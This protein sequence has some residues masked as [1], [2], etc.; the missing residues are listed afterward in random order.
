MKLRC[1]NCHGVAVRLCSR[2][3]PAWRS[4]SRASAPIGECR[5]AER[6]REPAADQASGPPALSVPALSFALSACPTTSN[7]RGRTPSANASTRYV[8][9]ASPERHRD[10]AAHALPVGARLNLRS[11]R[12]PAIARFCPGTG[13]KPHA[14]SGVDSG[15]GDC[16]E[17]LEVRMSKL[18][19][20]VSAIGLAALIALPAPPARSEQSWRQHEELEF[21]RSQFGAASS[22]ALPYRHY[23]YRPYYGRHYGYYAR[24]IT[25]TAM[26]RTTGRTIGPG[27]SV[28]VGP[29]GFG[30]GF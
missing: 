4:P 10:R 8:D 16:E 26:I 2:P 1:H 11:L 20:T 19:A 3:R 17:N 9:R 25:P 12:S 7:I 21:D 24:R 23:G 13:A 29:F 27:F 14:V 6:S 30:F 22:P 5:C 28:G 18:L 15:E